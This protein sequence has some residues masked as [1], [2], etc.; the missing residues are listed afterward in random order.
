MK[1]F[2]LDNRIKYLLNTYLITLLVFTLFRLVL[3]GLNIGKINEIISIEKEISLVLKSLVFGFRFDSLVICFS[4]SVFIML[5]LIAYFSNIKSKL[6]Y[7]INHYLI[8]VLFSILFSISSIDIPYFQYFFSRFTL[9][10]FLWIDSFDF[11][12]KMIFQEWSF[13]IYFILFILIIIGFVWIMNRNYKSNLLNLETKNKIS[14]LNIFSFLIIIGLCFIGMRGRLE[15]KSPLRIGTAYFSNYP[16]LNQIGLNPN[17]TLAKSIAEANELKK[18]GLSLMDNKTAEQFVENEFKD[19]LNK[20]IVYK[21][22]K[23]LNVVLVIMES[24]S[25]EYMGYFT[26]ESSL[27][28]NLDKIAKKSISFTNTYTAG[29]HTYNGVY[30]TLFSLPALLDIH[31]MK[32]TQI[33]ELNGL[34]NILKS[35]G[36]YT[37]YFTTHDDQFDNIGGFLKANSVDRIISVKDYPKSQIKSTLGVSDHIMFDKAIQTINSM[38]KTKPFFASLLTSSFHNPYVYPEN[39]D[40]KAKSKDIKYKMLEYSDWAIGRFIEKA[41]ECTWFENT[42]FV[43]IADHGAYIGNNPYPIPLAY[44]HT[45]FLIYSPNNFSSKEID[46][47]CLQIDLSPTLLSLLNINYTHNNLGVD[48]INNTRKYAYFSSDDRI[49]VL[50]DKYLYIWDKNS[51]EYLYL[52]KEKD[53]KNYIKEEREKANEMKNYAF[54]MIQYAYN[55]YHLFIP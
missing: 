29:I 52:Y 26:G 14:V 13:I 7:K 3:V 9:R 6:F 46:N 33:P 8:I 36:Y 19:F 12:V 44:H 1:K 25:A 5:F 15:I 35:N 45:P 16:L 42:V 31:S 24:M 47:P 2:N 17:Y 55:N 43:F 27:T 41:K 30:S 32:T 20:D 54:S 21:N 10:G 39:I 40:L 34:P 23:K 4:L 50:D 18:K 28:P 48:I 11:V 37:L 49:G 22:P 53:T 38:D 51:N